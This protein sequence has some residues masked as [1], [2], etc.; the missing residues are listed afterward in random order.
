MMPISRMINFSKKEMNHGKDHPT[1]KRMCGTLGV[2]EMLMMPAVGFTEADTHLHEAIG[3]AGEAKA[4]GEMGH[5]G[6]AVKHAEEA[7]SHA[8][9]A[10]KEGENVH[11][12]EGVSHLQEAVDHGK[13]GHGGIAGEHSSEAIE[14]LKQG[15]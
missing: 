12:G 15:H 6:E 8:K 2:V 3:Y 10:M 13:Q 4:H 9:N 1:I 14:H 5:A 7:K 11:V